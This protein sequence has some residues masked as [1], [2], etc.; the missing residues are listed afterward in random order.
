[1]TVIA[2]APNVFTATVDGSPVSLPAGSQAPFTLQF[3]SPG[4]GSGGGAGTGTT[5]GGT[6]TGPQPG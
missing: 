3:L 1:M 6:G 2:G 4:T 5:T